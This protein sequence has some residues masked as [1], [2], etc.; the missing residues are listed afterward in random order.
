VGQLLRAFILRSWNEAGV[1]PVIERAIGLFERVGDRRS[2]AALHSTL[3]FIYGTLGRF[4]E[5]DASAER[6]ATLMTEDGMRGTLVYAAF[7]SNRAG[8][9]TEEGRLDDAR[10]DIAEAAAVAAHDDR[11][12][13][14]S[15]CMPRSLMIEI[16]LGNLR[17]AIA[18]AGEMLASEFAG[19]TEVRISALDALTFLHLAL[20]EIDEAA[21]AAHELLVGTPSD[22]APWC[23]LAAI[24]ALRGETDG[25]A[26][27]FGFIEALYAQA[28]LPRNKMEQ[29]S[30]EML[31]TELQRRLAPN[32]FEA[33]SAQ[34]ARLTTEEATAAVLRALT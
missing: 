29:R 32:V 34:G 21:A 30:Y 10:S 5:A 20:G 9:R 31:R 12:F 18:I 19:S 4:A 22:T 33:L 8:L 27:L 23:H 11:Y 25:A 3:A 13:L 28:L 2:L 7:L 26:R 15:R 1:I 16:E 6:A 24:V 17:G 14:V